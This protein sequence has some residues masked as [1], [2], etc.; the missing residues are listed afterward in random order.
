MAIPDLLTQFSDG[1][2]FTTT[3]VSD[4][5]NEHPTDAERDQF[6]AGDKVIRIWPTVAFTGMAS[7]LTVEFRFDTA[8]S[9]A[10]GSQLIIAKSRILTV[11]ELAIITNV[12]WM[13]IPADRIPS[14]YDFSGLFYV[15]ETEAA[16]A[17]AI[18]AAL[19]SGAERAQV[20]V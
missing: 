9:L 15:P 14:G 7:G 3:E 5:V 13:N 11:A 12:F 6:Y 19:V 16:S 20:R 1:Q 10:S 2:T 17:G 18:S 4:N 8:A